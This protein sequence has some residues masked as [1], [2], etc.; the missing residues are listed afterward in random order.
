MRAVTVHE[1]SVGHTHP[2]GCV[3]GGGT[4]IASLGPIETTLKIDQGDVLMHH[5]GLVHEGVNVT[6]G[7]RY[8]A[9]GLEPALALD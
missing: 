1:R 2:W 5:S 4:H 6:A 8:L 7:T 9:P 3:Q